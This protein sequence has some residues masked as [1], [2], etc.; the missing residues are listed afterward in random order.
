LLEVSFSPLVDGPDALEEL[1]IQTE[2]GEEMVFLWGSILESVPSEDAFVAGNATTDILFAVDRSPSMDDDVQ[3]LRDALPAFAAELDA[4][5]ADWRVS[6]TVDD[7]GCING[8]DLFVDPSFSPSDA[9]TA[10]MNML[11]LGSM[12]G[13]NTERAFTLMEA[14][15]GRTG[16]GDCNEGMIRS[17]ATL[18]L[19]GVSDEPEQSAAPYTSFVSSFQALKSDPAD[20][21]I[22]AIGPVTSSCG[23]S[24]LTNFEDA[25]AATGGSVY[26]IC[27]DL[28]T[29]LVQLARALVISESST[30]ALS[31]TPVAE[32]LR[33]T[34][35]G[36]RET[37]WSYEAATNEIV[38]DAGNL[39][40]DGAEVR[41]GYVED[42]CP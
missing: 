19:V 30:F 1:V 2:L 40:P 11:V 12:Y 15:L 27:D 13:S 20:V 22:H 17:S 29:N 8:S 16:V 14:S 25:A 9:R 31:S 4:R 3:N 6:M 23:A 34:V 41:V 35:D 38:F 24:A 7:D 32:T 37:A 39:P 42:T 5:G 10:A 18:N 33:V 21:A 36:M 28:E 26:S